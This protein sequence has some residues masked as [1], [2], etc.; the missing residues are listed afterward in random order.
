M[1][2]KYEYDEDVRTGRISSRNLE[3]REIVPIDIK[4]IFTLNTSN[5]QSREIQNRQRRIEDSE[6]K[7]R[8]EEE[9]RIMAENGVVDNLATHGQK[10][11][12]KEDP[13]KV[14]LT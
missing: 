11:K 12:K 7:A 9:R 4:T 10:K 5:L 14:A 1:G 3:K 8:R 2:K 13:P 6:R